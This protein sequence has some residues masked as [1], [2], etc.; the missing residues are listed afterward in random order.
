MGLL[1]VNKAAVEPGDAVRLYLSVLQGRVR[2]GAVD[3][4]VAINNAQFGSRFLGGA[5]NFYVEA[6][7][8]KEGWAVRP[9]SEQEVA[10]FLVGA[11]FPQ[12]RYDWYAV[13]VRHGA[14]PMNQESW[15]GDPA[16]AGFE[17]KPTALVDL[18]S[19]TNETYI[20]PAHQPGAAADVFLP[21]RRWDFMFFGHAGSQAF[22][23]IPG[24]FSHLA[25]YI[26]RDRQG[27]PYGAEMTID[28]NDLQ[29]PN[30]RIIRLP[31]FF[32]DELNGAEQVHLPIVGLNLLSYENRWA[33]RLDSRD[34]ARLRRAENNIL[35]QVQADIQDRFP[36]Q[37]EIRWSGMLEDKDIL[38]VDDGR[39]N[40]ANCTDYWLS[41]FEDYGHV[42]IH[43]SRITAANL[44]DYFM[45]D[46]RGV[47]A[48]VSDMFNPF[49]PLHIAVGDILRLGFHAVD[50]PPHIFSCDGTSEQGLA[51]PDRLMNKSHELG[52]IDPLPNAN[53]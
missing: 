9:V 22:Y 52:A 53:P 30:L 1:R 4:Y 8:F 46:P 25:M 32:E 17:I 5:G 33:K 45:R 29:R 42:C 26:G 49:P 40:G 43:G 50:P 2:S 28:L 41:V 7:P 24:D 21:L 31:E 39:A 19:L 11:D 3:L 13:M 37:M 10:S 6:M 35:R 20:L 44:E 23:L 12:G 47:L 16:Q 14:S 27:V 34:L 48:Q 51:I 36:Y 18:S 38:L 15:L